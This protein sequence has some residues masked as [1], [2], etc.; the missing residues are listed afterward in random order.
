MEEL[1]N[2][3]ASVRFVLKE[4]VGLKKE[5]LDHYLGKRFKKEDYE[6]VLIE[7]IEENGCVY[8]IYAPGE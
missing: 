6:T 5:E 1:L 2:G 4:G 7:D 8:H 3:T